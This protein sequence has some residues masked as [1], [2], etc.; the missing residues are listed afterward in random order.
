MSERR[1]GLN[2]PRGTRFRC[3]NARARAQSLPHKKTAFVALRTKRSAERSGGSVKAP[4]PTPSATTS[5]TARR[6]YGSRLETRR[7]PFSPPATSPEA[8][9]PTPNHREFP[10]VWRHNLFKSPLKS[11]SFSIVRKRGFLDAQRPRASGRR[12]SDNRML[13]RGKRLFLDS[14]KLF[15]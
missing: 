3:A 15:L 11:V 4:G 1:G 9:F 2:S 10:D 13:F 12:A 5:S 8:P 7:S 6:R 14:N